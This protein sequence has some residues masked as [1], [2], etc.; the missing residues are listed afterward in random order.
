MTKQV[1]KALIKTDAVAAALAHTESIVPV[2]EKR[3]ATELTKKRREMVGLTLA[4]NSLLGIEADARAK[5]QHTRDKL[6][7]SITALEAV[8]LPGVQSYKPFDLEPLTWRDTDGLPRLVVFGLNE[9][10]FH[11]SEEVTVDDI[12]RIEDSAGFVPGYLPANLQACYRDIERLVR[13][14][15]RRYKSTAVLEVTFTGIIPDD[16][17]SKITDA[18]YIFGDEI[19]IVAEPSK[20]AIR[21]QPP[22][23]K[24]L[25]P[26][27]I[28]N[29]DPLV[30][31]FDGKQ[32]R[33][34]AAFDLTSIEQLVRDR[35]NGTKSS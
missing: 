33:L 29:G 22:K 20:M 3:A 19:Y 17:K 28:R 16:V 10:V 12:G 25:P 31:G 8:V 5:L 14:V 23:R 1:S 15:A 26:L 27:P 24:P 11:Y 21:K 35:V 2:D 34:I 7:K 18:R 4:Q 30:I 9:A 13:K 6:R 32:Y